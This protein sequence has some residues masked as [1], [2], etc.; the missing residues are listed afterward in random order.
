MAKPDLVIVGRLRKAHGIRG[1]ILVEPITDAPAEVLSAGRRLFAGTTDGH[2]SPNEEALTITT[3]RAFRDGLF[4]VTFAELGDRTIAAQFT[5]RYLF[6]PR[7]ELPPLA[8]GQLYVDDLIGLQVVDEGGAEVGEIVGYY[9]LPQ[10]LLIEVRR[11]GSADTAL[12]PYRTEFLVRVLP[13]EKRVV[14][15]LPEGMLE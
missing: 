11:P 1:D 14:M 13:D 10:N 12:L 2:P 6:A 5:N 7:D 3:A 9:E 4:L 8:E 15:R